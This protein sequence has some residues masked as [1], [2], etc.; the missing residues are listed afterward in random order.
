MRDRLA[1]SAD[2]RKAREALSAAKRGYAWRLRQHGATQVRIGLSLGISPQRVSQLLAKAE[3]LAARPRW[4]GQLPPRVL[5]FLIIHDLAGKPEL[6]AAEALARLTVKE[7]REAPGLGKA[8]IAA[9]A[10]WLERLGLSLRDETPTTN[11]KGA[12]VKGRP[13]DSNSSPPPADR[14]VSG[15]CEITSIPT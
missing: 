12:P 10:A 3:R 9:L 4:H 1:T 5:S 2:R 6:E 15:L 11:K 13:H 14:K 7:L 8:A